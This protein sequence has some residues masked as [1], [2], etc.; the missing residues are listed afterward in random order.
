V[1]FVDFISQTGLPQCNGT[2]SVTWRFV[3]NP[4]GRTQRLV[5]SGPPESTI[6]FRQ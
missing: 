1:A 4:I 3:A 5:A 2:S 6:H